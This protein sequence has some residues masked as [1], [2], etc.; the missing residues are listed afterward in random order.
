M[1]QSSIYFDNAATAWP[2]PEPVYKFMDWFHRTHG[3][4]TGTM[5]CC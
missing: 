3:A 2:K 4:G 1:E 5:E